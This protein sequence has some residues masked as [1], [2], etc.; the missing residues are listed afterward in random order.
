[1]LNI[2]TNKHI[3]KLGASCSILPNFISEHLQ[4]L[5]HVDRMTFGFHFKKFLLRFRR[6]AEEIPYAEILVRA[7]CSWK[8]SYY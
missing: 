5:K 6:S 7:S 2:K 3:S 8:Q 1:M 4:R